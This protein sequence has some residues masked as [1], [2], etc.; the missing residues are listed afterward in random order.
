MTVLYPM[1]RDALTERAVAEAKAVDEVKEIIN[2][3]AAMA[4]YARQAKNRQM[5]ADAFEIRLR[6][7]R[8]IGEMLEAG[9][10]ERAPVGRPKEIGEG[11]TLLGP[12]P[13]IREIVGDGDKDRGSSP[14][15]PQGRAKKGP[16]RT[17]RSR[18]RH[19]KT[20]RN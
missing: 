5:E 4:A 6:A 15:V 20:L 19:G 1:V 2:V 11:D 17:L 12:P 8:R 3:S 14:L 9:K 18:S 10:E 16:R 7:E 13:T